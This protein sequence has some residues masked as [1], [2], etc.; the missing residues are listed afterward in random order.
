[1]VQ[2]EECCDVVTSKTVSVSYYPNREYFIFNVTWKWVEAS[3]VA[4]RQARVWYSL[5][6]HNR[7]SL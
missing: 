3:I 1:M 2:V 5:F 4:S 7:A 6:I